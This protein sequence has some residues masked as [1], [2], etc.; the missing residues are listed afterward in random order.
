LHGIE[1]L[2][3]HQLP[4]PFDTPV[5]AV[6]GNGIHLRGFSQSLAQSTLV[7]TPSW[8]IHADQAGGAFVFVHL[9]DSAG[10]KV[11]QIDAPLD[12]GMFTQ[13]QAG[14]QFDGPLPIALPANLTPGTYRIALG[15]YQPGAARLA[16][17]RGQALSEDIDGPDAIELGEIQLP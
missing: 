6:F 7:I 2:S 13:W 11:A 14:Q 12:Q 8:D 3:I 17:S 5:G 16:L 15:V 10:H 9:L 4:R 1:Y